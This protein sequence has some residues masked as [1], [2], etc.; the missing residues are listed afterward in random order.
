[1]HIVLSA[2]CS[3]L[4]L[5]QAYCTHT[6]KHMNSPNS[7]E[8]DQEEKRFSIVVS[9]YDTNGFV[10]VITLFNLPL[11]PAGSISKLH[12]GRRTFYAR[13]DIL[14]RALQNHF[15]TIPTSPYE[16]WEIGSGVIPWTLVLCDSLSVDAAHIQ[17]STTQILTTPPSLVQDKFG[18][19]PVGTLAKPDS[20]F[21]HPIVQER[22]SESRYY[23]QATQSFLQTHSS[24]KS[25]YLSTTYTLQI[26][27]NAQ[28]DSSSFQKQL[29]KLV[30]SIINSAPSD[31][32]NDNEPVILAPACVPSYHVPFFEETEQ[33]QLPHIPVYSESQLVWHAH[34]THELS[35]ALVPSNA[36]LAP[37]SDLLIFDPSLL[38]PTLQMS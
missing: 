7:S 5:S 33:T 36:E 27:L 13:T 6:V 12:S 8:T 31:S 34:D 18:H 25:E 19:K 37:I 17:L 24:D 38:V 35:D 28:D 2:L 20:V 3:L 11:P 30:I 32:D 10:D 14:L 15:T 21:I 22:T 9:L 29:Q 1:M 23:R 16:S 26:L 4:S